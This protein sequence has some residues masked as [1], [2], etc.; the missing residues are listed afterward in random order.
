MTDKPTVDWYIWW[1]G[2]DQVM[3]EGC[4]DD[5]G[6][7]PN[8]SMLDCVSDSTVDKNQDGGNQTSD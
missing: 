5:K 4:V 1:T 8:S 7:L 2:Q 6:L 3:H